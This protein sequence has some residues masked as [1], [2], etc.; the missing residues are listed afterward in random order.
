MVM[1]MPPFFGATLTVGAI[2][3]IDYFRELADEIDIPFMVQGAP[4]SQVGR[5]RARGASA[6]ACIRKRACRR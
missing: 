2:A 4:L 6:R 3:V 5:R 1:L